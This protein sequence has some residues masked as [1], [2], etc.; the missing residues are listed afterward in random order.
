VSPHEEFEDIL[1]NHRDR[2]RQLVA[3]RLGVI[4]PDLRGP[5]WRYDWS[6]VLALF[7]WCGYVSDGV[8]PQTAPQTIFRGQPVGSPGHSWSTDRDVAVQY[9]RDYQTLRETVVLRSTVLPE[10]VLARFTSQSEIVV[11]GSGLDVDEL[12][13]LPHFKNPISPPQLQFRPPWS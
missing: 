10:Q 6:E 8:G 12:C 4:W 2:D 9:A 5:G 3:E 11:D 1:A 13:R 7:R